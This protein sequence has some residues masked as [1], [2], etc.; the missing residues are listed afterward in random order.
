M[1]FSGCAARVQLEC[2][3][4]QRWLV[5]IEDMMN[6]SLVSNSVSASL[7]ASLIWRRLVMSLSNNE[8]TSFLHLLA[9]GFEPC[10][11]AEI[12]FGCAVVDG[13]MDLW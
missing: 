11:V 3:Q 4:L 10:N 8:Y 5:V 12:D 6:V 1:T 2:I 9:Q 13:T 7:S